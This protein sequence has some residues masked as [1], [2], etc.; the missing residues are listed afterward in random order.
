MSTFLIFIR[1]SRP[2][3][4]LG[5][6]LLYALGAGIARYLGYSLDW[7]VYIFGQAW[8]TVL[9]IG[10]QF[11][12]EYFEA[13]ADAANPNRTP[14][15]RGSGAGE[16][17]ELPRNVTLMAAAGCLVVVAA[18]GVPLLQ[19]ARPGAIVLILMILATFGAVLYSVPPVRLVSSGYGEL[20][21][22]ILFANLLPAFAF[23]LQ[24]GEFHRLLAMATFP[25]S[26][27]LMA[28]VLAFEL[29][30]YASD[31]KAGKR[32]LLVRLGWQ[33][34]MTLHNGL[35]L[36]GF[37]ILGLA[38]TFGLPLLIALPAFFTLPLGVLQI[39]QMRRIAD[40]ARPNWTSLTLTAAALFVSATYLLAFAFWTR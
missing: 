27:L 35:I 19:L 4:L 1:L 25:L 28:M 23:L 32:T 20:A 3:F 8:A 13:P 39:W 38:V 22:T 21:V 26:A 17:G 36:A 7:G 12:I 37:L 24:A 16:S 34:A 9:Q 33:A 18:L 40:G 29:P 2:H 6:M 15:E 31:I 5:G 10:G 30:D 11:L 14:H